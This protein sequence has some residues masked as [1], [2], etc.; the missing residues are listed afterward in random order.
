MILVRKFLPTDLSRV[1]DI[2]L[3]SFKDPYSAL[4]LLEL[5][6]LYHD[7]FFVVEKNGLVI[8]YVISRVVSDKG[9]ILAIAVDPKHRR[10]GIG[11]TLMDVVI[12]YFKEK[13]VKEVWLE[14][15]ASNKAGR[16]F[17]R[18]LNFEEKGILR[19]YYSD[20][21]AAIVLKK[22]FRYYS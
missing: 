15:R 12:N 7:S 20:G 19:S 3:Q 11:R 16:G 4:F 22:R 9:H 17:Y 6:E 1:Y 2:E 10:K 21:E 8:G 5:Y 13:K 14:V 18:S